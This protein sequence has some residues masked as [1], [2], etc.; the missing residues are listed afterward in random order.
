MP[1]G[2]PVLDLEPLKEQIISLY[3]S[4]YTH[5]EIALEVHAIECIIS[6]RLQV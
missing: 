6:R 1:A 5:L 3:H 2:R 4:G